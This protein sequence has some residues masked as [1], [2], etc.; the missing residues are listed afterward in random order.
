IHILKEYVT[1][2]V[3]S[4]EMLG[5]LD[6]HVN[7]TQKRIGEM[8]YTTNLYENMKVIAFLRYMG[9]LAGDNYSKKYYISLM[10]DVGLEVAEKKKI[11]SYSFGMKKKI[12]IA[13]A[14]LGNPE[15]IILDEPTSGLDPE[16]AIEIRKLVTNLQKS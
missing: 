5:I 4:F 10:K 11:K 2:S 12:S 15:I 9:D 13:Q 8:L 1:K 3:S 7:N 14:L 16:S 6:N